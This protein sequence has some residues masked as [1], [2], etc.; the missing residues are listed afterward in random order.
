LRL[1]RAITEQHAIE[2]AILWERRLHAVLSPRYD[3]SDLAD[4]DNRIQARLDALLIAQ[5]DCWE[6]CEA[7]LASHSAGEFFTA[8]CV[9]GVF[10]N[11]DWLAQ[12]TRNAASME[13]L[14]QAGRD[15]WYW[16]SKER[17][18]TTTET[19]GLVERCTQQCVLQTDQG[20]LLEHVQTLTE[21]SLFELLKCGVMAGYDAVATALRQ[22]NDIGHQGRLLTMLAST[23]NAGAI[24]LAVPYLDYDG[25]DKAAMFVIS[26]LTG[27]DHEAQGLVNPAAPSEAIEPFGDNWWFDWPR[28]DASGVCA[29]L[30][31]MN[32]SLD[33]SRQGRGLLAG[34]PMSSLHVHQILQEGCNH[35]RALAI[36]QLARHHPGNLL[37][38]LNA[39]YDDQLAV[40]NFLLKLPATRNKAV[41]E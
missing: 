26:C 7:G 3:G 13:V 16:G 12:V 1:I 25:L 14:M 33:G 6:W 22:S 36:I 34:R 20:W 40:T 28:P 18:P 24:G 4:F 9:A 19:S 30:D 35:H 29:A 39:S 37:I 21:M 23:G 2:M 17:R 41:M 8:A 38:S 27:L 11:R 32:L 5:E 31:R 15:G 10:G